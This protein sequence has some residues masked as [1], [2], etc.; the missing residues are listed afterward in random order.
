MRIV[1]KIESESRQ[2]ERIRKPYERGVR[3]GRVVWWNKM[4]ID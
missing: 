4:V 1:A 3:G 2:V